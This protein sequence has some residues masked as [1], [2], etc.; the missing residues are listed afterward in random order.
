MVNQRIK[1]HDEY[2]KC[3]IQKVEE[4]T[5][6]TTFSFF[7]KHKGKL[8]ELLSIVTFNLIL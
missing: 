4:K 7:L 5:Q 1:K 3:R 6:N 2:I 8:P